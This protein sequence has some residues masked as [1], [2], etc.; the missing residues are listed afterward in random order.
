MDKTI[1]RKNNNNLNEKYTE[2]HF[3]AWYAA[4]KQYIDNLWNIFS[5]HI[6]S[7]LNLASKCNY[8][9]FVEFVYDNSSGY[10]S[11]FV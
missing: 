1:N 7:D 3:D 5:K 4:Y 6:Q 9:R 11:S 2:Q 10:I 8:Y